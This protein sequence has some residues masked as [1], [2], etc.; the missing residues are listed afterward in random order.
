MTQAGERNTIC[1]FFLMS[2]KMRLN[3]RMQQK[4]EGPALAGLLFE[5]STRALMSAPCGVI[6]F[7]CKSRPCFFA[8][9]FQTRLLLS[10]GIRFSEYRIIF[11]D[12]ERS[13]REA[14]IHFSAYRIRCFPRAPRFSAYGINY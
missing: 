1:L 3:N 12:A 6:N 2:S 9:L 8:R 11:F 5:F 10:R 4:H 7:K 14:A 13:A